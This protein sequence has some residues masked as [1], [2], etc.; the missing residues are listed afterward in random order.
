MI[1]LGND[2]DELLKDEFRKRY[3]INLREFLKREYQAF[4]IYP[5]MNDIFNA[6]KLTAYKD[7]RAVILGQ[8]PYHEP[9][10]AH[11]LCFSV[12]KGV[13]KPPSLDNIFKEL[14]NDLGILPPNHGDLTSWAAGGVLLLNTVLTVR[15]GSANSHRGQ[16]WEFFTDKIIELLNNRDK[17]IVFIL[18][19][20]NARAKSQ[21]LTNPIHKILTSAHPSPLS[22]HNGFFGC[23]HFSQANIFLEENN[24]PQINWRIEE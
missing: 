6:L 1:C 3:Y 14:I 24:L 15:Q 8:D 18:W 23:R 22:A 7:V 16:G 4:K 12:Q 20:M 11:G 19:G 10:Q 21:L 2:W 9:G 17:P 13:K 5:D